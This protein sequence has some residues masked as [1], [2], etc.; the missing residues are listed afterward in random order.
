[1]QRLAASLGAHLLLVVV[2]SDPAPYLERISRFKPA[3]PA[4]ARA[5]TSWVDALQ[6]LRETLR[7]DDLVAV[8]SARPQTVAWHASLERVPGRLAALVPESFLVLYPPAPAHVG[9]VVPEEGVPRGLAKKRIVSE[10]AETSASAALDAL[11]APHYPPA[12]RDELL[13]TILHSD[14]GATLEIA[15]G[16]VLVH[17]RLDSL[18]VPEL[19]LGRSPTGVTFPGT[20]PA[21]L[22]F[23]LLSPAARP[24]E[25]LAALA[26]VARL[27]ASPGRVDALRAAG[28]GGEML[29]ALVEPQRE[30]AEAPTG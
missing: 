14:R 22:V 16:V 29:A 18:D 24:G 21:Q 20:G 27:M 1:M 3:V 26:D 5:V 8:L 28:T 19:Y 4:T 7:R 11:L 13:R 12:R 15:S 10:I 17:A 2:Q 23:L 9:R 25:H 30:G 6:T